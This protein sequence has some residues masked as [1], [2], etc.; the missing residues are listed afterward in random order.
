MFKVLMVCTGN[1]CRSPIAAGLLSHYLPDDLKRCVKVTSAGTHALHG[2][3]AETHAMYAMDQIGID[4]SQH[5]ARQITKDIA[6]GSD[7][8]LTMEAAHAKRVK[9]LLGWRQNSPRIITEF[10]PQKSTYDIKDPYGGILR[11]YEACIQTLKPCIQVLIPW[12]R[13]KI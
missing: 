13:N 2:N 9:S 4:I 11:D 6:R 10:D 1:I 12:L 3:Q 7:L 8:I 5:R